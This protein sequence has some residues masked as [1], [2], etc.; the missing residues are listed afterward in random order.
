MVHRALFGVP[1]TNERILILDFFFNWHHTHKKNFVYTLA[2]YF[3]FLDVETDGQVQDDLQGRKYLQR[4]WVGQLWGGK[5]LGSLVGFKGACVFQVFLAGRFG[6]R[7]FDCWL[8]C[9][10]QLV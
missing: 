1:T 2:V 10:K 9:E 5:G 4:K 8:W 6:E 3:L 7:F